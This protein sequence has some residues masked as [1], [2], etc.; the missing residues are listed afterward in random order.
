MI[1]GD[2]HQLFEAGLQARD[3]YPELKKFF[4]KK[5]SNL[6]WEEF[7]TQNLLC[8][9]IRSQV[10]TTHFMVVLEKC[11]KVYCFRWK[12]HPRLVVGILHVMCLTLKMQQLA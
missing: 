2:P 12:K 11:I 5:H 9:L 4:Y 1:N 10:L 3:I 7:L 8:G 6:T